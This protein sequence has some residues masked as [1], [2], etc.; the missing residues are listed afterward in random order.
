MSSQTRESSSVGRAR[1]CQGRGRG[2]ESRLPLQKS[3]FRDDGTFFMPVEYQFIFQNHLVRFSKLDDL[4]D[5]LYDLNILHLPSQCPD[6]GTGRHAGLKILW[7][8]GRA[9]SSPAPGTRSREFIPGF[10]MPGFLKMKHVFLRKALPVQI[11]MAQITS[12]TT[13]TLPP[14]KTTSP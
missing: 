9:G 2:F 12:A 13:K 11:K 6:G 10:F 5:F 8:Y 4:W 1:P 7:P 3:P 14:A